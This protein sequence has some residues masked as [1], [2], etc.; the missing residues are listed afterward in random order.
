GTGQHRSG[1]PD[2]DQRR[3]AGKPAVAGAARP[4]H[5]P[6]RHRAECRRRAGRQ[7]AGR[8]A[9][10]GDEMTTMTRERFE[11]LADAYGG[12]L[13]RWPEAEREAGRALAAADP[14]AA[15]LLLEADAVDALLDS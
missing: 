1:G 8:T 14:R 10:A 15:A 3:G 6:G 4:A 13:R 2:G 11:N 7:T 9:M 5:G 12:D